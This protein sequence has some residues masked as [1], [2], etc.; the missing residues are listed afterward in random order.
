M[1]PALLAKERLERLF[2]IQSSLLVIHALS[3]LRRDLR[4]L[5]PD[6]SFQIMIVSGGLAPQDSLP[7]QNYGGGRVGTNTFSAQFLRRN[8]KRVTKNVT[9]L[10]TMLTSLT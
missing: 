10:N 5:P 2:A 7:R 1:Y 4:F 9:R 3:F 8:S 6:S